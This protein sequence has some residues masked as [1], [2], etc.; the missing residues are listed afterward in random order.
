[1]SDI[2]DNPCRSVV[3]TPRYTPIIFPQL[4]EDLVEAMKVYL[5]GRGLDPTLAWANGW[6]PTRS[7][8]DT[9]PRILI[10]GTMTSNGCFWQARRMVPGGGGPDGPLSPRYQSPHAPREGSLILVEPRGL[11]PHRAALVEGP[12]DALAAAGE[13]LWGIALMG[14]TPPNV[15]LTGLFEL[16]WALGVTECRIVEDADSPGSLAPVQSYLASIG[17]ATSSTVSYP[18][19]DLSACRREDRAWLLCAR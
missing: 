12:M 10:P 3:R 17:L 9:V 1:M 18:E 15:V 4:A 19:K 8:G 13:G 5:L 11:A 14:N 16:L 7:A 2:R 6:Y